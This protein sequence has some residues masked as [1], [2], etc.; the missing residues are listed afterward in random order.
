MK[1]FLEK[2]ALF[3]LGAGEKLIAFFKGISKKTYVS[4][5]IF[6]ITALLLIGVGSQLLGGLG[7]GLE[8]MPAKT[9]ALS[10]VL[11]ADAYILREET[12]LAES[13]GRYIYRVADGEKVKVGTHIA[14]VYP[15]SADPLLIASLSAS[16]Q[17]E[18]LLASAEASR[19]EKLQDTLSL[20]IQGLL[21]LRDGCLKSGDLDGAYALE[22]ELA[23]YMLCR[24]EL[25]G[26]EDLG[27]LLTEL[28]ASIGV[29]QAGL[30]E[31]QRRVYADTVGWFSNKVDGYETFAT[32]SSLGE[33]DYGALD[34]LFSERQVSV[35]SSVGKMISSH[36]FHFVTFLSSAE[37]E[38]F[39]VNKKY[40]LALDGKS[41]SA[42]LEKMTFQSGEDRVAL[43]FSATSLAA[44]LDLARISE[45]TL[46]KAVHE[47]IRLPAA[48]LVEEDGV[49]G[50]YILKGYVVEFREISLA[51]REGSTLILEKDPT[52]TSGKHRV[53]SE[54]DNV[55][56]KGDDLYDGKILKRIS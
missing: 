29:L 52:E 15:A 1:T 27:A 12:L 5:V 48:A 47:G 24:E 2:V 8:T 35:P 39:S 45:L 41:L 21:T 16:L 50:V 18:K 22:K 51:Y 23:V 14:D 6:L 20:K 30:G 38:G 33:M 54:N 9:G 10:E 49:Y 25:V 43:T 31:P 37:A 17:A 56:I 3:F 7:G 36:I 26:A 46:V 34:R 11:T 55:I 4:L 19:P 32:S 28:R 44:S 42:T 53:L 13:G 40:E